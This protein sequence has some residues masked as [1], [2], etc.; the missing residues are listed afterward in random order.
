[1]LYGEKG[2][3]TILSNLP[4]SVFGKV[5]N[6]GTPKYYEYFVGRQNENDMCK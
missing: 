5:N 1:M 6:L 3:K 2:S 4:Y